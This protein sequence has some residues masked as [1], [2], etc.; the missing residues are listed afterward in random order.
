VC[1]G[2]PF[3]LDLTELCSDDRGLFVLAEDTFTDR[4]TEPDT[5]LSGTLARFDLD[6]SGTVSGKRILYRTTEETT[7]LACDGFLAGSGGL[8][9]LAEFRNVVE[10]PSCGRDERDALVTVNKATGN[11]RTASGFSR[12]DEA[13]GQAEC[14]IRDGVEQLEVSSD[15]TKKYAGFDLHGLW[16]IGPTPLAFTPDVHD[17]FGV[18]PDASVAFAIAHD[19]GAT[20]SIDLYRLTEAQVEHGALP[21]TALAPCGSFTVPNDASASDPTI[22]LV[23]SMVIAPS[24]PGG[25]DATALVTFRT[26]VTRPALDLLP[27]FGDLRGTVAFSL[28][29]RT[30]TCSLLGLVTLRANDLAR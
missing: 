22:T 8:V 10:S 1:G 24:T 7:H 5:E 14:D 6:A 11:A 28:P 15:G 4:R 3:A 20:A 9:Y 23:T 19:R 2:T 25:A 16:R 18:H 13:V 27:P 30:E 21:V 26:R 17:R 29:A 12:L